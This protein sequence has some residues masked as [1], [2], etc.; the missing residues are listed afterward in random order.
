MKK[1][2]LLT[3]AAWL[4][5][6]LSAVAAGPDGDAVELIDIPYTRF[7]LDNGLTVIVH[8]DP[9]APIVAVNVW[10]HVGSKNEKPGKTGFAHLFEHL[11]FEGTENRPEDFPT[12]FEN[13]GATSQNGTTDCDRTNYFEN[14][15]T[16]AL[17][18]ALWLESDRM[19]HLLGAIDQ[20]K[21]DGQRGVVQNE[22]RQGDNQPYGKDFELIFEATYPHGHPYSWPTI[23]SMEDLDAATLE[24]VHEWFKTYYG[25]ANAVLSIAGDVDTETVRRKVEAYFGDIPSGPPVARQQAWVAQRTGTHRQSREDRVPQARIYKVWNVSEWGSPDG[26]YLDLVT[27]VL[28]DGKSSRLYKRLVYDEQIATDVVGF[29]YPRELGGLFILRATAH[30]GGDLAEVERAMDEELARFLADG[31]TP[32]ELE[33]VKT[34]RRAGF[35]RGVERI[36]GFGGKS[37]ILAQSEVYG[38]SPDYHKVTQKRLQTATVADLQQAAQRWLSDGVFILE[39][40]PFPEYGTVESS[41]DRSQLPEP[42]E[43]PEVSF[44]ELERTTLSNGLEV[45]LAER[46]AIP[47]VSFFLLLDAGYAADQFGIRGTARLALDMLDEGTTSRTALEISDEQSRLGATLRAASNLDMSIVTLSALKENLPGSLE[48]FADIVLNPAFP[49]EDFERLKRQQL[50]GIQREKARPMGMALRVFPKLLYGDDHA[51]GMPLSGSGTQASVASLGREEMQKFHRTWFKPNHAT[52]VVVGDTTLGEI[53]PQIEKL[54]RA[55][56]PGDVPEK[57]I[58]PVEHQAQ[59]TIYLLDRPGSIQSIIFAGHA[60]PPKANPH[61]IAIEVMNQIFGG[62][63]SSRLNLNLREDKH[64]SYGAASFVIDSQGQ[65]PF[66][67][68]AQ[69]QADK[70]KEAMMEIQREFEEILAERPPTAEELDTAQAQ[71][72]LT[73]PGRWETARSVGFSIVEL[74]RFGLPDDFWAT[75]AERVRGLTVAEVS[76]AAAELLRPEGILWVVVGDRAMIEGGVRELGFGEIRYVDADGNLL[77]GSE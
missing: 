7:V 67:V 10:Y 25:A 50:A 26:D 14:V 16:S 44:P 4:M 42:G 18:V 35:I 17:D 74:A 34:D 57:N 39:V 19:G 62:G 48:L 72:S 22:K 53:T 73:L 75:Y 69:L 37:D 66:I 70:T 68:F 31:P 9:K 23:G 71:N 8:E 61:E 24:D 29:V 58:A 38:G 15:P 36:G 27:G 47:V 30:P 21:L 20:E 64:W 45:I 11:M 40:R 32:Q 77:E 51:Y 76:Q 3:A 60:A 65:R 1:I 13:V 2:P 46:H 6:S 12:A 49:A 54:F 52:L 63:F 5:I 56:K 55:W 59:S 43:S 28:T 41:V 33:R